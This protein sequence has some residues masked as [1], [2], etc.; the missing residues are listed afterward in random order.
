MAFEK[1]RV[2]HGTAFIS[3]TVINVKV[4]NAAVKIL[5]RMYRRYYRFSKD[6]CEDSCPSLI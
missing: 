1:N 3:D 5:G 2:S 4:K 6:I